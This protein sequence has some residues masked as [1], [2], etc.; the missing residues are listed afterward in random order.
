MRWSCALV[1]S[2][3]SCRPCSLPPPRANLIDLLLKSSACVY[4]PTNSAFQGEHC[5]TANAHPWLGTRH[6]CPMSKRPCISLSLPA[7]LL[8]KLNETKQQLL[9]NTQLLTAVL[10]EHISSEWARG[11]GTLHS[12]MRV[13]G[14]HANARVHATAGALTAQSLPVPPTRP[15]S[16]TQAPSPASRRALS[17][18]STARTSPSAAPR[19]SPPAAPPPPSWGV[20]G[21]ATPTCKSG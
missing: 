19:S 17:P 4:A 9:S 12:R 3:S 1:G 7:A 14:M 11:C 6:F 18:P 16:C 15:L 21:S 8:S 13:H 10:K 5:A 2:L 20:A